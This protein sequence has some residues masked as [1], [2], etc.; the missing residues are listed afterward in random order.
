[1]PRSMTLTANEADRQT[2]TRDHPGQHRVGCDTRARGYS[3][4][5]AP[6]SAS[7]RSFIKL[8]ATWARVIPTMAST[9]SQVL[10]PGR[11]TASNA[12]MAPA[13]KVIGSTAARVRTSHP[14][15]HVE[16]TSLGGVRRAQDLGPRRKATLSRSSFRR[17]HRHD[18]TYGLCDQEADSGRTTPAPGA[19]G[20]VVDRPY[21]ATWTS[22]S[23]MTSAS[24]PPPPAPFCVRSPSRP[25]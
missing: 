15:D 25:T 1:M 16:G 13:V 2:A 20:V 4:V 7:K 12:A 22:T 21:D 19:R 6:T 8:L 5:S 24:L 9:R 23:L 14:R 11:R 17:R 3:A 10:K 18:S